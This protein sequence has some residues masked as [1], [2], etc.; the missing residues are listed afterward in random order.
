VE[1][2]FT[3]GQNADLSTVKQVVNLPVPVGS[4]RRLG[5]DHL[6]KPGFQIV[7]SIKLFDETLEDT[8]IILADVTAELEIIGKLALLL[9]NAAFPAVQK[10]QKIVVPPVNFE[11]SLYQVAVLAIQKGKR[12]RTGSQRCHTVRDIVTVERVTPQRD[13]VHIPGRS[14]HAVGI[15]KALV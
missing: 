7:E 2:W 4:S 1:D 5:A 15:D 9:R 6:V 11:P 12:V 13:V 3:A 10:V 8:R 14:Y